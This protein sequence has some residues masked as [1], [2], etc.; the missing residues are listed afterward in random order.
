MQNVSI[1]NDINWSTSYS[2]QC[3]YLSGSDAI[4]CIYVLVSHVEGVRNITGCI[5]RNTSGTIDA[6]LTL[7]SEVLA[8]ALSL[9]NV[10]TQFF[11]EKIRV[12]EMCLAITT[13]KENT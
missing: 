2:L 11:R 8:Y 1:C 4:G 6:D 12:E 10:D 13:G 5:D 7:Y 9:E 3:I